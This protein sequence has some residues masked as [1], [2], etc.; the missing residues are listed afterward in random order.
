MNLQ[1]SEVERLRSD[2]FGMGPAV[3]I[4]SLV[5]DKLSLRSLLDIW[6]RE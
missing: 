5:L 1:L 2:M 4:L 3:K 6:C